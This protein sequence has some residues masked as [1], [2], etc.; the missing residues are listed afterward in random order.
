MA[1]WAIGDLHGCY[2]SLITLLEKIDFNKDRDTLW[3]TGDLVNRGEDSLKILN[4]LYSIKNAVKISLGNHDI[5]LISVF[6]NLQKSTPSIQKI[7]DSPNIQILIDWIIKQAF[8]NY[9]DNLGYLMIHAGISPFFDLEKII[10]FSRRVEKKLQSKNSKTWLNEVLDT[11]SDIYSKDLEG[12]RLDKY[13]I[14]SFTKLRYIDK[15]TKKLVLNYNL[16]PS[17]RS[18]EKGL[19]P[20]Y[21]YKTIKNFPVKIIFGHWSTLGFYNDDNVLCL[22]SGCIWGLTLTAVRLDSDNFIKK[23]IKCIKK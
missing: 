11:E 5:Y 3:L 8:V 7:I 10:S 20:W 22:D 14:N 1:V 4:Y 21:K 2:D 15:K 17:E 19:K 9:D 23:E 12:I 6:F 16:K 13:I 18:K